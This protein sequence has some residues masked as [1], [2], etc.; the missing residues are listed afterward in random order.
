[1]LPTDSTPPLAPELSEPIAF[2][3]PQMT[4]AAAQLEQQLAAIASHYLDN[5][6]PLVV[7]LFEELEASQASL[8]QRIVSDRLQE[9]GVEG[10]P[11]H[12]PLHWFQSQ[13]EFKLQGKLQYPSLSGAEQGLVELKGRLRPEIAR[14]LTSIGAEMSQAL[15]RH[16]EH[17][18]QSLA[19]LLAPE[20]RGQNIVVSE[21]VASYV[22]QPH[23]LLQAMES[24]GFFIAGQRA[25]ATGMFQTTDRAASAWSRVG[26]G[27]RPTP[28]YCLGQGQVVA[29]VEESCQRSIANLQEQI[30]DYLQ[31]DLPNRIK[32]L[33]A[34]IE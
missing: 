4:I 26:L 1:M 9:G 5:L 28:E 33:L 25:Q 31:D 34:T 15:D 29:M 16:V 6:R 22:P 13:W 24:F 10:L 8:A 11:S 21:Y 7:R 2:T 32:R 30:A 18:N 17:L 23:L 12:H 14:A 3:W 20:L 19:L 27:Q